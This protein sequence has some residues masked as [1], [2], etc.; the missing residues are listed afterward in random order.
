MDYM[1]TYGL[2]DTIVQKIRAF[3]TTVVRTSHPKTHWLYILH[4]NNKVSKQ[5]RFNYSYIRFKVTLQLSTPVCNN[6][7]FHYYAGCANSAIFALGN[8]PRLCEK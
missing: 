4:Y 6:S 7:R 8:S 1:V 2:H 3:I 5:T